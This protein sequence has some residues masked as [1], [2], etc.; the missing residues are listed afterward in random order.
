[1]NFQEPFLADFDEIF[2]VSRQFLINIGNFFS[3]YRYR[4]LLNQTAGGR[5][6]VGHFVVFQNITD[7]P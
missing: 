1:M 2:L 3:I 7:S 4:S 6:A 5:G